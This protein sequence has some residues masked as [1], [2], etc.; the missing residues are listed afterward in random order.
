MLEP[1]VKQRIQERCQQ[2][3]AEGKLLFRAQLDQFYKTFRDRF[4]PDKLANLDGEALLATMHAHGN[5]D[6][7][8]YWLEFKNDE[9]FPARFGSISGGSAFKFGI[10]RRK[11]TN[12]WVTADEGNDAKDLTVDEA[13]VIARKHRDQLLKGVERLRQLPSNGSDDDYKRLQ[14]A[15]DRD[16]PDVSGLAWGHKYFSLLFPD[17]L[18]ELHLPVLQRFHLLKLLQSPPDGGGRY[19]CAT[20]FVAAA[21][22]LDLPMNSLMTVLY[23]ANGRRHSYWRVGTSDGTAPRNRWALMKDG[24][25]V[26]VGWPALGDLSDVEAKKES[27]ERLQQLLG[28][29]YPT[30]PQATGR[31]V[32]QIVNFVAVV[33]EGDY[34]LPSDG[35][36]V[37]GVGRVTG[38]YS[39]DPAS[40]FPH[41]RPVRWLSLDEW[42]MPE[43]EGLQTTVHEIKK[44]AA[45][46]L[47]VERHAQTATAP[48]AVTTG[49]TA[50]RPS[51]HSPPR[52]DGVPGRVQAVL[53]RKSQ[54]ILYGPPGTGKTFW[55]E[56]AAH[57]LAAYWA[58]GKPFD[59]LAEDEKR[60]VARHP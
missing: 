3:N 52:L 53:D 17:K 15:L 45:N 48:V 33:E 4:G 23:S 14:E 42:K 18:D 21:Q 8:V 24:G 40:D 36:S 20:R 37:L 32:V 44:Y 11:E 28:E 9:E 47:E 41:R 29:K 27:R 50:P 43:K 56:R 59:Q 22:E 54:C 35:G 58:F 12:T 13:V 6:S 34:V 26:A 16:A 30:T 19:L 57:D 7:L 39:F 25:C 46:I 10:F 38:P 2:M 31:A 60:A 5:K 1:S 55:A 51:G 49:S